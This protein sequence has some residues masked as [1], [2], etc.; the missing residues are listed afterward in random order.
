MV[1]G[2]SVPVGIVVLVVIAL[3][4]FLFVRTKKKQQKLQNV[5]KSEIGNQTHDFGAPPAPP[6]M[7][8]RSVPTYAQSS[9]NQRHQED[10]SEI[11][12]DDFDDNDTYEHPTPLQTHRA[13][14]IKLYPNDNRKTSTTSRPN[15]I[16]PNDRKV[17]TTASIHSF[18]PPPSRK[19]S[20]V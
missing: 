15:L 3:L 16:L 4:L 7:P 5:Q 12:L 10:T 13:R 19:M 17:S 2:I 11:F 14:P 1:L 8:N 18:K 20:E 9:K 6:P